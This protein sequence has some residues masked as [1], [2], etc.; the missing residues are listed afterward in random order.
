MSETDD[1]YDND[2][3]LAA[4][5]VLH[6]L[7]DDERQAFERRLKDDRQLMARVYEW[8][9]R[10]APLADELAEESPSAAVKSRLLGS[11]SGETS[12]RRSSPLWAW[13]AGGVVAAGVLGVV[14][15]GNPF[16]GSPDLTPAFQAEL[17][18][19]DRSVV[20]VA[21]VIPATHEIVI[22]RVAGAPPAGSIHELWLIADGADAP[23]SLGLIENE[24]TTRIRV[25]DDIAPGVRTG[26]I[27]ISIEPPGGSP[28]GA[29]TGPVVATAQFRDV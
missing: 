26:T 20:L 7:D 3:A 23:V 10:L 11:I 13:L 25:P 12:A 1:A 5:Y 19:E 22:D 4:E 14:L 29:P 27:A 17:A 16:T 21:G 18:S 15:L 28:T 2:D 6:L 9:A 8:E 24:G